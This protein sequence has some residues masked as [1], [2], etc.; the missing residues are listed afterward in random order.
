M[1]RSMFSGVSGLRNHQTRM[2][3]IGNNI[4]NVNTIG[5]K[6]GR[7]SFQDIL[8]QTTQ[9]AA[10]PQ[11]NRGGTNPMQVGLGMGI[12]TI[13]TLFT[14]G[15]TQTTGKQTDLALQ[16]QGFF[17]VNDGLK[18]YY[19]R[20]GNFDFDTTGNFIVPGTGLKVQ[21]WTANAA[22]TITTSGTPGNVQIPVGTA[23]A[24]AATTLMAFTKNLDATTPI[25]PAAGSTIQKSLLI[26]DSLGTA[27]T[28][29]VAF[30]HTV[31]GP[32]GTWT[33][34]L[35]DTDATMAAA[36][37]GTVTFTAA[38]AYAANVV[39]VPISI[40]F[41]NGALT[42]MAPM[43]TLDLTGLTQY[44]SESTITGSEPDGY[45][46]GALETVTV[47]TSGVITGRFSNGRS[48]SLA[49]V[50]LATFNNPG[51]LFKAAENTYEQSSNSGM[52]QVGT[53]NTGGRG[54]IAPG[55]LEM[56]N[57]DLSQQFTDMI[58]TQR[59]FQANSKIITA[60]DE[61]I[62]DLVNLKR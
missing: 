12:A 41:T 37:S 5:F 14:D 62:Q 42:P 31:A 13:D 44:A 43:P 9:G 25:A 16:G 40:T 1:M 29:D 18:S 61:M 10:Q 15:S 32:P 59:G 26:Y 45:A 11:G 53:A 35:S 39:G 38:G 8:S 23:M 57:V 50:A 46:A 48:K 49:Q 56:S 33:W 4:A 54:K 17:I 20:A 3:V 58:V 19:T 52:A 22:G 55:S 30:T 34:T 24:P 36:G 2:D 51:G 28:V 27:H 60:S 21:G 7:V 6:G 47:N